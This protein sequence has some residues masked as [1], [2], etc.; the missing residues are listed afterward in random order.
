MPDDL[1]SRLREFIPAPPRPALHAMTELSTSASQTE[2]RWNS[3]LRKSESFNEEIPLHVHRSDDRA[4]QEL[5]A[6]LRPID[7]GR[8]KV[9]ETT[10]LPGTAALQLID[11]CLVGGDYPIPEEAGRTTET[12]NA[13]RAFAW[14]MLLQAG[15]LV[16]LNGR[17]LALTPA[18]QKA[19]HLP[20]AE[21]LR[22]LWNHWLKSD[23]FDEF[24]RIDCVKGQSGRGK[25]SL[26]PPP[27]RRKALVTGLR[28]CPPRC[29]SESSSCWQNRS[30]CL[31]QFQRVAPAGFQ[32]KD[33]AEATAIGQNE[34]ER[35]TLAV[36]RK[37]IDGFEGGMCRQQGIDIV[38]IRR[39]NR[40]ADKREAG[41]Q[42]PELIG[43]KR[44]GDGKQSEKNRQSQ[45]GEKTRHQNRSF[46]AEARNLVL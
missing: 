20:A 37:A 10:H 5:P 34:S 31:F 35:K 27:L 18:G 4:C 13:I 33:L 38:A 40:A 1:K 22:R 14:P 36:L 24:S 39:P 15:G 29:G 42:L 16:K 30:R 45:P 6:M 9:S 26:T 3:K 43:S 28:A 8:I 23:L 32:G 19:L 11:A 44:G 41:G 21:T 46:P 12:K 17:K 25:L 7:A 2:W